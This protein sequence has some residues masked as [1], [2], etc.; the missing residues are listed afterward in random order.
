MTQAAR[1]TGSLL[2][3]RGRIVQLFLEYFLSWIVYKLCEYN[4]M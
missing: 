2:N 1:I 3:Y 4:V